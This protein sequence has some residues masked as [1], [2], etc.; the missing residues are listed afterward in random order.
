[1]STA[2][3][4]KI[5]VPTD[6][7]RTVHNFM[8]ELVKFVDLSQIKVALDVGSYDAKVAIDFKKCFPRA[9]IYAFECNPPAIELCK[10]NIGN[11]NDI[12]LIDKAVSDENGI[13]N[14]YPINPEKTVTSHPNGNIGASSIYIANPA[15]PIERYYQEQ[16]RV[17]SITLQRWATNNGIKSIDVLWMDLQGAELKALKGLGSLIENVKTIYTEVT[18]KEMYLGQPLFKEINGYLTSNNF[19]PV[20]RFNT[21][22]WFGDVLYVR[23]DLLTLFAKIKSRVLIRIDLMFSSLKLWASAILKRWHFYNKFIKAIKRL[24]FNVSRIL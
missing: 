3:S 4:K 14:F 10:R 15:Y 20:K 22:E 16:I 8:K 12:L 18:Y 1:M 21:S 9:K 17:E 6:L 13:I 11:R 7:A 19:Y 5:C 23:G 2:K 24:F